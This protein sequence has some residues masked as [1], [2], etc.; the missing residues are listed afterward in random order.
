MHRAIVALVSIGTGSVQPT[1]GEAEGVGWTV[2][3]YAESGLAEG[4]EPACGEQQIS[5]SSIRS[6]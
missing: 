6:P 3:Q 1:G 4:P 2:K 5:A